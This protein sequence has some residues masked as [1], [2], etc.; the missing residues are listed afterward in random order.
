MKHL[1]TIIMLSWLFGCASNG[2]GTL[3][4][5]QIDI[6]LGD[7]KLF[8]NEKA[9][10]IG[11]TAAQYAVFKNPTWGYSVKGW[12][13]DIDQDIAELQQEYPADQAT[14]IAIA[15]LRERC[16]FWCTTV[17]GQ[18]YLDN[19]IVLAGEM[20]DELVGTQA[21]TTPRAVIN[22]LLAQI[23]AVENSL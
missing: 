21:L 2:T 9:Y 13:Q 11:V 3:G 18:Q 14:A 15:Y 20:V 12:L 16:Q 10:L 17:A 19:Y 8:G 6:D 4:N 7:G 1:I 23:D 22:E 5:G